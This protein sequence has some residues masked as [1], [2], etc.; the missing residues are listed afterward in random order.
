V[1]AQSLGL[2]LGLVVVL[3]H[4]SKSGFLR[5]WAAFDVRSWRGT[6]LLVQLLLVYTG[7]AAAE[8]YSPSYS[9]RQ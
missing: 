5:G 6:L 7:V 2:I 9:R 4:M 3:A 1:I 8:I